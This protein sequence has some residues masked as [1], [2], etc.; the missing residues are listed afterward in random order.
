MFDAIKVT[1]QCVNWI[2]EFFDKNG[3]NCYCSEADLN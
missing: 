3:V 2:K 1:D